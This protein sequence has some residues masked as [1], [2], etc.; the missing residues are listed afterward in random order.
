MYRTCISEF[1]F[2]KQE[3]ADDKNCTATYDT[4]IASFQANI[5]TL[6]VNYFPC[7]TTLYIFRGMT[8]FQWML[9][10]YWA[11]KP[12]WPNIFY[13]LVKKIKKEHMEPKTKKNVQHLL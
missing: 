5:M 13:T 10:N 4:L 8:K 2:Q 6:Y 3:L 1:K 7:F 9:Q 12:Y 11:K